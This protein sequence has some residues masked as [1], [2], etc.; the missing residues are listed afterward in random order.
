MDNQHGRFSVA[1][2]SRSGRDRAR[3]LVVGDQHA[4]HAPSGG[5][6]PAAI[7]ARREAD[8]LGIELDVLWDVVPALRAIGAGTAS[9][10]LLRYD[11]VVIVAGAVRGGQRAT[12]LRRLLG[13]VVAELAATCTLVLVRT[14]HGVSPAGAAG[15]DP[16]RAHSTL[17]APVDAAGHLADPTRVAEEVLAAIRPGLDASRRQAEPERQDA[18]DRSLAAVGGI[19]TDLQRVALLARNSFEVPFAQIN[20]VSRGSL[21]SLAFTGRS[22]ADLRDTLS[23]R[24]V[25]RH[26]PVLIADTHHDP[27]VL[28]IDETHGPDAIRFY[29]GHPIESADGY[30][31]GVLCVFDTQPHPIATGDDVLLRDIALLAEAEINALAVRR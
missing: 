23:E 28:D 10:P 18:V 31:I 13:E 4:V 19:T 3:I 26:G 30:R 8:D 27:R 11:A 21:V 14:D 15:L 17:A 29:A 20:L 12:R 25:Q 5:D 24:V 6:L 22:S 1:R 2:L 16:V 7:V 9:W